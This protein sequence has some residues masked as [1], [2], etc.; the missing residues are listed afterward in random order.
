MMGRLVSRFCHEPLNLLAYFFEDLLDGPAFFTPYY[1]TTSTGQLAWDITPLETLPMSI[2]LK[3]PR[4]RVPTMIRSTCSLAAWLIMVS[5]TEDTPSGSS[6]FTLVP[7]FFA[8]ETV[9]PTIPSAT[10]RA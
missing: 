9:S 7:T 3:P 4:P 8:S 2:F 6:V 5:T 10:L 1:R